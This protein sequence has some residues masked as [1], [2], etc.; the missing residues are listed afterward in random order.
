MEKEFNLSE[1]LVTFKPYVTE[2]FIFNDDVKEF[3]KLLKEAMPNKE[4]FNI[5]TGDY[6]IKIIDKL[7]G[8][9]LI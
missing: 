9:K 2:E 6:V 7:A 1:K 3:I 5:L 4:P 8:P